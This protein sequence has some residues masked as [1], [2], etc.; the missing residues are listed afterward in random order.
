MMKSDDKFS[1]EMNFSKLSESR[2]FITS[3]GELNN[4]L[5]FLLH[6]RATEKG[7]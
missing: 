2:K 5:A 3:R 7:N 1:D 4:L 6:R